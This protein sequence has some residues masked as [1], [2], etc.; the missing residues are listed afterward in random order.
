VS[1][2]FPQ[3]LPEARS[4]FA[5]RAAGQGCVT[6]F[7]LFAAMIVQGVILLPV[8]LAGAVCVAVAPLALLVVAP[9]CTAYGYGL[10]RA[11]VTMAERWAF[12]RQPEL[13]LAV[14]ASRGA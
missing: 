1:V 12:W 9:L 8:A 10:W 13:L 11:G 4:P 2:R 14:D 5:G 7:V 3:R 6:S